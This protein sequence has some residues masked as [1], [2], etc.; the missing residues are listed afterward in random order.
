MDGCHKP[1]QVLQ[2]CLPWQAC[3]TCHDG[4]YPWVLHELVRS[5]S[6]SG[7]VLPHV[8]LLCTA[9]PAMHIRPCPG[10][11]HQ[12]RPRPLCQGWADLLLTLG[13]PAEPPEALLSRP[14]IA[15]PGTVPVVRAA[16]L[17][18]RQR[19]T[20]LP[21][22]PHPHVPCPQVA[23]KGWLRACSAC[24]CSRGQCLRSP[25]IRGFSGFPQGHR[26][27]PKACMLP[28]RAG[29]CCEGAMPPCPHP[30]QA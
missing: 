2:D 8:V 9:T 24:S 3:R 23:G 17:P 29:G 30:G 20:C 1:D 11:A 16:A 28:G 21:H 5:C 22:L 13:C 4:A 12:T 25:S 15:L 18:D 14:S 6:C 19:V 27:L 7:A 26:Q 10:L